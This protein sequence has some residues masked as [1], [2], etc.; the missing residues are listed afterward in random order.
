MGLYEYPDRALVAELEHRGYLV[1]RREE[2]KPL[3]WSRTLPI[4]DGVDFETEALEK[5]REQITGDMIHM[6]T[7]SAAMSAGVGA[8]EIRRAVLRVL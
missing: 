1:R 8:P 6:E 2:T 4:P 3:M 7:R 5:L